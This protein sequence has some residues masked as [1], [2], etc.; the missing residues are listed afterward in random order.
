MVLFM[1]WYSE[2]F[3][4]KTVIVKVNVLL[5]VVGLDVRRNL[6]VQMNSL[7][8]TEHILVCCCDHFYV[9]RVMHYFSI[10]MGL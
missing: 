5:P 6:L 3:A 10:T 1:V 2:R 4:Y 8:T 9:V 7:D